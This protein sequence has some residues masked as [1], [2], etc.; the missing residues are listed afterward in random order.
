MG[1]IE[2]PSQPGVQL[3]VDRSFAATRASL[4]PLEFQT[5]DIVGGH[6]RIGRSTGLTTII[7]AGGA[8]LSGRNVAGD[9]AVALQRL[10]AY[11]VVD[12]GFGAAQELS[13]NLVR[14]INAVAADTGGTAISLGESCRKHRGMRPAVL[15]DLRIATTAALG[16]GAGVVEESENQGILVLP[17]GNAVGNSASGVLYDN[18]AGEE[19]PFTLGPLEGFRVRVHF[20]MGAAGVIRW[21][22]VLDWAEVPTK[23]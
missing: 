1:L 20:T 10:L 2:S 23:Y 19:H 4:R 11:A 12:T 7:A 13:I 5:K 18:R 15:S 9:K 8:I 22:F 14:T 16:A 21:S 6:Y 17:I 3:E